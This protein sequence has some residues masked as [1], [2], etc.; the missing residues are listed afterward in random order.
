MS[1]PSAK[2][3][4]SAIGMALWLVLS[5]QPLSHPKAQSFSCPMSQKPACLDYN[6]KVCSSFARCVADDAICFDS[7]TCDYQGFVC[8]SKFVEVVNEFETV[9][10]KH[11]RLVDAYSEVQYDLEEATNNLEATSDELEVTRHKLSN[12]ESCAPAHLT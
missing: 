9:I 10:R 7:Y 4:L 6:D 11:N 1:K 3:C 5:V 2:V 12:F 8:K